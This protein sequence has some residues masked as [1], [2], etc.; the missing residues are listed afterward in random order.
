VVESQQTT[1]NSD[2]VHQGV[3][4]L[5]HGQWRRP[6]LTRSG[7]ARFAA[8]RYTDQRV[9]SSVAAFVAWRIFYFL[10]PQ[11]T[12]MAVALNLPIFS[13]HFGFSG[14]NSRFGRFTATI[15][16]FVL[17]SGCGDLIPPRPMISSPADEAA[18]NRQSDAEALA[19]DAQPFTD[20]FEGDWNEW[21]VF[22]LGSQVVGVAEIEATSII[23]LSQADAEQ[24]EVQYR[25]NERLIF[26]SGSTQFIRRVSTTSIEGT[27][28]DL[29]SF[30][31]EIQTG[32]IL[33]S[34]RGT[35][36]AQKISIHSVTSGVGDNWQL[37]WPA[38][39]K[40]LF[41]LEQTFR[42]AVMK[43]GE[44]RRLQVL[45]PSLRSVGVLE[46]RCTGDASV[47]MIDG[48]FRLLSE[49]EVLVYVDAELVDNVVIW[50]N[51]DGTIEKTLRT[52]TRLETFRIDRASAQELFG[53][54]DESE[55]TV[56][57]AGTLRQNA[58]PTQLGFVIV[59]KTSA[60][61]T[62]DS[63]PVAGDDLAT[64]ESVLPTVARQSVRKTPDGLQVLVTSQAKPIAGFE[65]DSSEADSVDTDPTALID[66]G[67]RLVTK[68]SESV[69][70]LAGQNLVSEL[71]RV[72]RNSLSLT[73]Q[74]KLRPASSVLRGGTGGA[75]DHAIVLAALMRARGIPARVVFGL[76]PARA[77]RQDNENRV[78]MKLSA[79]VI[80]RVDGQWISVDPMTSQLNRADQ[81]CLEAPRGDADLQALLT[82]VFRRISEIEIQIRGA[83]YK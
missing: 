29:K 66:V 35:R 28:G 21:Y 39:T 18:A 51:K 54:R 12:Q 69:G 43:K 46:L 63:D 17:L 11:S 9:R 80:V 4:R 15:A 22:R 19:N 6:V 72:A 37:A 71:S 50:T 82:D 70:E 55:V 47:S 44:T 74:G 48:T 59:P 65:W 36:S 25:R 42:R 2:L 61:S 10:R 7:H 14:N 8:R 62:K 20:E 58:E 38:S 13:A 75:M 77:N 40:G 81:L 67:H 73:P 68:M 26:R 3:L 60:P 64:P 49:I 34:I 76:S 57:V 83:R 30:Q 56:S 27:R 53:Q 23:D 32:P 31:S 16:V 78:L 41:A 79:W 33:S 5:C 24:A 1:A 45:M 52:A